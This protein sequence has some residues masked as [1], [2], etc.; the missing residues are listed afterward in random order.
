[1][2]MLPQVPDQIVFFL[3]ILYTQTYKNIYIYTYCL[4]PVHVISRELEIKTIEKVSVFFFNSIFI[5]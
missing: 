2:Y 4:A 1:M 5:N 3:Y